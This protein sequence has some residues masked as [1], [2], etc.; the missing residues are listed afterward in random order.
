MNTFTGLD[1]KEI[2]IIAQK[3]E[4]EQLDFINPCRSGDGFVL[5]TGGSGYAVDNN[6]VRYD[7]NVGDMLL[8]RDAERYEAHFSAKSS[9]ITSAY[10]LYFDDMG[11]FPV[12]LPFVVRCN[13]KQI[14]KIHTMCEIWQERQW[15]S[16][17]RCRIMLLDFYLD[18]IK[19]Y[20][21]PFEMS[22]D[23][24]SAVSYIHE[25]FKRNFTGEEISSHCSLSLSYLRTKFLHQT[26][27]TIF[28]YRDSLRIS[29]AK[30]MLAHNFFSVSEIAA[31]LGYCDVYHFSKVFK[32]YTGVSPTHYIKKI[33]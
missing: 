14:E 11:K 17:T 21:L 24:S 16:Y 5:V 15:D 18:L 31:E 3:F 12:E 4:K 30:E 27:M 6:G 13:N 33:R 8:L 19:S 23:I 25:N 7:I 26:K 10:N 32:K 29:A 2:S 1:I 20:L 28:Q 9:Y 22:S